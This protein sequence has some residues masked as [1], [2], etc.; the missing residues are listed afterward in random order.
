MPITVHSDGEDYTGISEQLSLTGPGNDTRCTC[1]EV[2]ED[3]V[4]EGTERFEVRISGS[5][6]ITRDSVNAF[7]VDNDG[8]E[9]TY[10]VVL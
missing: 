6:L 8:G 3:E 9:G 7:I 1:V 5:P 2:L 4:A 10:T